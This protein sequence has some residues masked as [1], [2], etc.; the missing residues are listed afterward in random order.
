MQYSMGSLFASTLFYSAVYDGALLCTGGTA[1]VDSTY[2]VILFNA[3]FNSLKQRCVLLV[4]RPV[5]TG[6]LAEFRRKYI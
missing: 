6:V 5:T 1:V 2:E 3:A 4:Q